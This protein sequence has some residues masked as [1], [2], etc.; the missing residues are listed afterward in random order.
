MIASMYIF[1]NLF[2][3]KL[4]CLWRLHGLGIL[5]YPLEKIK[6][7]SSEKDIFLLKWSHAQEFISCVWSCLTIKSSFSQHR[8]QLTFHSYQLS[9][10]LCIASYMEFHKSL[11]AC[12]PCM[13]M[14]I[15]T[16]NLTYVRV[17]IPPIQLCIRL[18]TYFNFDFSMIYDFPMNNTFWLWPLH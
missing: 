11:V 4:T 17:C 13:S 1:S 14:S 2:Q 16:W 10:E 6:L 7:L 12:V 9:A 8:Q 3:L 15:Y 5:K 18:L